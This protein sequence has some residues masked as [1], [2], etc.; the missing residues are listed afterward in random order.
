VIAIMATL[1]KQE[2]LRLSERTKTGLAQA[3]IRGRIL[4]RPRLIVK[5]GEIARLRASGLSLRAIARALRISEGSVRR[6]ARIAA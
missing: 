4:G 3:R 5:S 2:R 1:A 6:L